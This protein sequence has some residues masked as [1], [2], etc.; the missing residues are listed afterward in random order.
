M[1][2]TKPVNDRYYDPQ[3]PI[4]RYPLELG[5]NLHVNLW[6]EDGKYKWSISTFVNTAD[7]PEVRFVG[8]RPFD[9]RVNW[10]HFGEL[11]KHGQLLADVRFFKHGEDCEE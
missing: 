6:S 10:E 11:L 8:D 4:P 9:K 5:S 2:L 3:E 7:G 1:E